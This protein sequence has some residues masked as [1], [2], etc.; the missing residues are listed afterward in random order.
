MSAAHRV[1]LC[2]GPE[3][4]A[5]AGHFP[6]NPIVPGAVLLERV[7]AACRAWRGVRV[8]RV[9]AKFLAP[10]RPDEPAEIVLEQVADP[11]RVRFSIVRPD[12]AT[13]LRGALGVRGSP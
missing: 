13:L 10:L 9:D 8:A 3:H 11:A 12:G 6:G 7:A 2:I 5:L 4:P 1:P